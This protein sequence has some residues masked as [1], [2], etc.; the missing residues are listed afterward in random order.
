MI[1]GQGNVLY[2]FTYLG[3]APQDQTYHPAI[4]GADLVLS[5]E[6]TLREGGMDM[7]TPAGTRVQ[8]P[9]LK[10]DGQSTGVL[11]ESSCLEEILALVM[12]EDHFY[13]G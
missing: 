1:I 7:V 6:N 12:G 4:E 8:F 9:H 2:P 3:F 13:A 5:N 11:E 10:L